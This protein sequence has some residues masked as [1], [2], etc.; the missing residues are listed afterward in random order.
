MK[1][2]G[3]L[4][5]QGLSLINAQPQLPGLPELPLPPLVCNE[6]NCLRAFLRF[7]A[8]SIEFCAAIQLP[9]TLAGIPDFLD[10]CAVE[11][12]A[13]LAIA[14]VISGCACFS[15]IEATMTSTVVSSTTS[16]EVATIT[17]KPLS[18]LS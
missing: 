5:L 12:T 7:E 17:G 14:A 2:A 13:E 9:L 6:D 4:L 3:F 15:S 8:E 10:N 16:T 11:V 1:S 18:S